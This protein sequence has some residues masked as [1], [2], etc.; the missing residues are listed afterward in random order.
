M[1]NET[2]DWQLMKWGTTAQKHPSYVACDAIYIHSVDMR[3]KLGSMDR[4]PLYV[5]VLCTP[6]PLYCAL[7][8]RQMMVI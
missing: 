4:G 7:Q 6:L 3:G 8:L 2:L 1:T 5:G